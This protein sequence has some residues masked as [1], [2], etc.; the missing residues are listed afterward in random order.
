MLLR[1]TEPHYYIY[2]LRM[3]GHVQTGIASVGSVAEYDRNRI[4][5]HEFTRPDKEDDRVRQIRALKAQTGPVLL[6]YRSNEELR[7]IVARNSQ[8]VPAAE[9]LADDG[10][11][12]AIWVVDDQEQ[13]S[14]ITRLV[15]AMDSLYIADGHHRSA[16]ASRV[17][18]ERRAGAVRHHVPAEDQDY[19]YFLCVAF[20]ENE[21]RIFDYNRLVKDLR[22][23]SHQE[24]CARLSGQFT[25]RRVEGKPDPPRPASLACTWLATGIG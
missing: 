12:H 8:G 11:A 21:M 20:P 25:L 24:F 18:A 17:A 14:A 7:A 6:A 4:R 9:V 22:G 19:N 16:A 1:D 3:G 23:Q 10:I 5:K 13:I 2:Q 15:N